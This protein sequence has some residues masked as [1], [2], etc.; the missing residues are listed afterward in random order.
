M[1]NANLR[2]TI[3]RNTVTGR[4]LIWVNGVVAHRRAVETWLQQGGVPYISDGQGMSLADMLMIMQSTSAQVMLLRPSDGNVTGWRIPFDRVI[5]IGPNSDNLV[6]VQASMRASF[7]V[8]P[9]R[10]MMHLPTLPLVIQ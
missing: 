3:R 5:W 4:S 7:I 10:N 8:D 1:S 9:T 6:F 2:E